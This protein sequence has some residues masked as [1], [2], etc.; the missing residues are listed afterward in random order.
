MGADE[1][2]ALQQVM[3]EMKTAG[4][5]FNGS[6]FFRDSHEH[7]RIAGRNDVVESETLIAPQLNPFDSFLLCVEQS[8]HRP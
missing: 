1:S 4:D 3:E 6:S 7:G 5:A 2:A 8:D